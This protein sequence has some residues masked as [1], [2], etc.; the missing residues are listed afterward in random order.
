MLSYIVALFATATLVAPPV[1]SQ[2]LIPVAHAEE[3]EI[4]ATSTLSIKGK[5]S[6]YAEKYQVSSTTM[7][8]IVRCESQYRPDIQ[9]GHYYTFDRPKLGLKAGQREQS[10]GLVQIHLPAHPTI[11]KA[12]ATDPDFALTFLAKEISKGNARIW[13]CYKSAQGG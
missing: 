4:S 13:S 3:I 8:N 9:S 6:Y 1:P 7:D 5:I 12:E 2:S 11:S 10:F